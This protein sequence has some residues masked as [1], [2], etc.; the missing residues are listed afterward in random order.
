MEDVH[1]LKYTADLKVKT[2]ESGRKYDN[3]M[4]PIAVG[5]KDAN[6]QESS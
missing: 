2:E 3:K 5:I 6:N 4:P 1:G